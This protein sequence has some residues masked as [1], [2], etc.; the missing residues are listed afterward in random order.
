MSFMAGQYSES[1]EAAATETGVSVRVTDLFAEAK[2]VD[3]LKLD[4]EG[5]EWA[6]LEDPRLSALDTE[7]IVMEWHERQCRDAR[8]GGYAARL[9]SDAG[10]VHQHETPGPYDSNGLLWAWR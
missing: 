1:R 7:A 4:I 10:F 6:I 3:L 9:L 5:G 8:P 2:R